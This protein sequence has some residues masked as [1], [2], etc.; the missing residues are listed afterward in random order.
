MKT[1]TV[2]IA[3]ALS[4]VC[5]VPSVAAITSDGSQTSTPNS[6]IELNHGD[7]NACNVG[8][9]GSGS[10]PYRPVKGPL[11]T[12]NTCIELNHGDWNACNVGNSGSGSAPY[13][14]PAR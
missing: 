11:H 3:V 9:S 2:L 8:N 1:K 4:L 6:C 10:A 12:P 7:W 13:L 14:P 5:A